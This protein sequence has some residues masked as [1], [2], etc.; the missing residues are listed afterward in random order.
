MNRN[1]THHITG[2]VIEN[3][4]GKPL[5]R[6]FCGTICKGQTGTHSQESGCAGELQV[7]KFDES[8]IEF[9][10]RAG[11]DWQRYTLKKDGQWWHGHRVD[12]HGPQDM[13]TSVR[14]LISQIPEGFF[15]I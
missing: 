14:L 11:Y 2:F 3:V 15:N 4:Y 10:T 13:Q 7:I 8:I 9:E 5:L 1:Q 12:L 6:R